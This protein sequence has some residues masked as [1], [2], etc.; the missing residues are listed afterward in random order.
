VTANPYDMQHSLH[1]DYWYVVCRHCQQTW[2]VPK[3]E[4][5]RTADV[6][7]ILRGHASGHASSPPPS[8]AP[9]M[10][11]SGNPTI[12]PEKSFYGRKARQRR[13]TEDPLAITDPIAR[14]RAARFVE[15]IAS[16]F[17]SSVTITVR[18][19][20]S[21]G[22]TLPCGSEGRAARSRAAARRTP[23][24]HRARRDSAVKG[25]DARPLLASA[26]NGE[27]HGPRTT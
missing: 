15:A 9:F 21:R 26:A 24:H 3:D 7:A 20:A 14:E 16:R 13:G 11:E 18:V 5:R 17:G 1:P 27:S 8:T 25:R 10:D 2:H 12:D 23:Q 19:R 22:A 6:P 4:R